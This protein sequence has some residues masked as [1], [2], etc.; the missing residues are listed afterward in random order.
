[1]ALFGV[2]VDTFMPE[3]QNPLPK[4]TYIPITKPQFTPNIPSFLL[5]DA[6]EQD[7]FILEQMS[8]ASQYINW[9]AET[10]ILVHDQVRA[11]NGRV[12]AAE[13]N[14]KTTKED[15]AEVKETLAEIT[16]T[17]KEIKTIHSIFKRK[18]ILIIT[19][20]ALSFLLFFVYPFFLRYEYSD[21]IPAIMKVFGP[22]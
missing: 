20:L 21:L 4:S 3:S 11:T 22:L 16:P 19:G 10:Q 6:S 14:I 15:L 2:Y 8:V 12:L 18:P 9:L 1:L 7:K 13:A 17:V 5:H